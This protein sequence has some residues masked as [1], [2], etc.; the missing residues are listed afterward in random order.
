MF[1]GRY[2]F[3]FNTLSFTQFNNIIFGTQMDEWNQQYFNFPIQYVIWIMKCYHNMNIVAI[4]ITNNSGISYLYTRIVFGM[5]Y[6]RIDYS[7]VIKFYLLRWK[8]SSETFFLKLLPMGW[9]LFQMM[10]I[11]LS[12]TMIHKNVCNRLGLHGLG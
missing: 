1:I 8:M 5:V 9:K 11:T 4:L 3:S 2:S 6:L 12:K 7:S 10:F